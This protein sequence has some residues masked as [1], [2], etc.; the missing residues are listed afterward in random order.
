LDLAGLT[1]DR[2]L[3]MA[4]WE[5][6]PASTRV[7]DRLVEVVILL[8]MIREE[9]QSAEGRPLLWMKEPVDSVFDDADRMLRR[10]AV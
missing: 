6:L 3:S 9:L 10:L 2:D 4:E 7:A 5:A 8:G 1:I